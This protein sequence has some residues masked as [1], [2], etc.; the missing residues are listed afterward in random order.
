MQYI[1]L[2]FCIGFFIWMAISSLHLMNPYLRSSEFIEVSVAYGDSVWMIAR[3]YASKEGMA[4]EL[5]EAIIEVN[6]LPPDGT[7]YAGRC[8]MIPILT[9]TDEHRDWGVDKALD[10]PA[11]A[12][13]NDVTD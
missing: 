8:L 2:F 11:L 13:Y 9:Y 12:P 7:V 5:E 10:T 4:Q 1:R 6:H 3:K